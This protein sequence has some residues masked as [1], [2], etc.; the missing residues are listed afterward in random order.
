MLSRLISA[1]SC[2]QKN[3]VEAS[4]DLIQIDS[5]ADTHAKKVNESLQNKLVL[6]F[7]CSDKAFTIWLPKSLNKHIK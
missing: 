7:H 1:D 6:R 3:Q 2:L 5:K 4:C